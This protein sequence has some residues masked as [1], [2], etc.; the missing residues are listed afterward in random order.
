MNI[1]ADSEFL[2]SKGIMDYSLLLVIESLS[3]K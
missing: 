3:N 1:D 2:A